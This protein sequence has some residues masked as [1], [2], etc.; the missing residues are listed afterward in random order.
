M[1]K[2]LRRLRLASIAAAIQLALAGCGPSSP[3]E[4]LAKAQ[5]EFDKGNLQAASVEVTN[6]LSSKP[7]MVE[8]R[9]LMAQIA[10]K[11]GDAARAEKDIRV[12]I[13]YGLP[14]ATAQLSL[15]RAI[16]L[17]GAMDRALAETS[18]PPNDMA[19]KDRALLLGLLLAAATISITAAVPALGLNRNG[20]GVSRSALAG[21]RFSASKFQRP[22]SGLPSGSS[23]MQ[24]CCRMC[25]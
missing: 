4:F 3:E 21:L 23:R 8:A 17:Q 15:V 19:P 12:A 10:L 6:A 16:L 9:W 2:T 5:T 18:I 14:R 22:P 24:Y 20:C 7:N 25:R 1:Q 13:Q 11:S